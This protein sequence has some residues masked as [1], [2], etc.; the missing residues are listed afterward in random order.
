M[1]EERKRQKQMETNFEE[2]YYDDQG[3]CE[4]HLVKGR[5]IQT[6]LLMRLS[7][8]SSSQYFIY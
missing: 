4:R 8:S 6:P 1:K 2:E 7:I 3:V 5:G